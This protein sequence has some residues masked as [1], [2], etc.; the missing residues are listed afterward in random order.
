MHGLELLSPVFFLLFARLFKVHK[1]QHVFKKS[2]QE[3]YK[4]RHNLWG[5]K[6]YINRNKW[7]SLKF[8]FNQIYSPF[9]IHFKSDL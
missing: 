4:A 1:L 3:E 8:T 2:R 6:D 9:Q 7:S 5:K